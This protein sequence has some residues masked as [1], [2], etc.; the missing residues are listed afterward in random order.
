M[1]RSRSLDIHKSGIFE[2]GREQLKT[3]WKGYDVEDSYRLAWD[4][5]WVFRARINFVLFL[6]IFA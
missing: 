1:A 4:E 3:Q 2:E 5:C 6:I